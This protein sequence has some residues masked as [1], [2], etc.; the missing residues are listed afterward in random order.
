M[1]QPYG[2]RF[3]SCLLSLLVVTELHAA[4]DR[5]GDSL[6]SGAVARF[7]SLAFRPCPRNAGCALSPDG[8]TLVTKKFFSIHFWDVAT[9]NHVRNIG[10]DFSSGAFSFVFSADS[11]FFAVGV[12]M[13]DEVGVVV[14]VVNT[15]QIVRRIVIN[16]DKYAN[17]V[18]LV[19]VGFLPGNQYLV[20]REDT[21]RGYVNV[22]CWNLKTGKE[23]SRVEGVRA[24]TLSPVASLLATGGDSGR[25]RLWEP[26]SGQ[27]VGE[28]DG[29][30]F[31]V[32]LLAF[33][34]NGTRLAVGDGG[35]SPWEK[36]EDRDTSVRL[37]DVAQQ[38][39]LQTYLGDELPASALSFSR[40]DHWLCAEHHDQGPAVWDVAT[41]E[42]RFHSTVPAKNSRAALSPDG[43]SLVWNEGDKVHL[44]DLTTGKEVRCWTNPYGRPTTFVF[45]PDGK[46]LLIGGE[47]LSFWD[48]ATGAERFKH[49]GH[50]EAVTGL[51]FSPDGRYIAST[52]A[53]H[54][55]QLWEAA[56]GKPLPPTL[57]PEPIRAWR[58][59]FAA[60]SKS[61]TAVVI[62]FETGIMVRTW[63]IPSGRLVGEFRIGSKQT[64]EYWCAASKCTL[65]LAGLPRHECVEFAPGNHLLAVVDERR[66]IQIWDI[67]GGKQLHELINRRDAGHKLWFSP[68]GQA[69]VSSSGGG[70]RLWD[71]SRGELQAFL[72]TDTAS[73]D[74][75][76]CRFSASGRL[77]CVATDRAYLV[78]LRTRLADFG[79]QTETIKLT[80]D[81][82]GFRAAAFDDTNTML[83]ILDSDGGLRFVDVGT[84]IVRRRLNRLQDMTPFAPRVVGGDGGFLGEFERDDQRFL[85]DLNRGAEICQLPWLRPCWAVAPDGRTLVVATDML[86]FHETLTGGRVATLVEGHGEDIRT[87]AF[88]PDGRWLATGSAPTA[89]S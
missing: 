71:V 32:R 12:G 88:S 30:G 76:F 60:D 47:W 68:D 59:G 23:V 86:T 5:N 57:G 50:R 27:R 13:N 69:L 55:L 72:V 8:K 77:A 83:R 78:D 49:A 54:N 63:E 79:I 82:I 45:T 36:L 42:L 6:P 4:N 46:T 18:R 43:R 24:C 85:F 40:D 31:P 74:Q 9:G 37:W 73:A 11:C 62:D 58:V 25:V 44:T 29:Q 84:G 67:A 21:I 65:S 1:S 22:A 35:G 53:G 66:A 70:F 87:L 81:N 48:V 3:A 75:H 14:G 89:L 34:H 38:V 61:L 26:V 33:S 28:L 41:G 7:G 39:E 10:T 19:P 80:A 64:V 56:T 15:G 20:V 16:Q 52:D 2:C 51:E 17:L